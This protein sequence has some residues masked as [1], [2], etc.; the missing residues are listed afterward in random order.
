[1][2]LAAAGEQIA[3]LEREIGAADHG[4]DVVDLDR[5]PPPTLS[6]DRLPP[7]HP[8]AEPS[9]LLAIRSR[10]RVAVGIDISESHWTT[11]HTWAKRP[12]RVFLL[13]LVASTCPDFTSDRLHA[14]T[15]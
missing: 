13:S 5:G 2:T 7:D 8:V 11:R 1:M 10:A 6:A 9:P 4:F 14:E 12:D 3:P 15:D